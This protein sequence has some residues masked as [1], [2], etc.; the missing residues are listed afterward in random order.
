MQ[1][2]IFVIQVYNIIIITIPVASSRR[3]GSELGRVALPT[4]QRRLAL[5]GK[6]C[7]NSIWPVTNVTGQGNGLRSRIVRE[8]RAGPGITGK[9]N[10]YVYIYSGHQPDITQNCP[11]VLKESNSVL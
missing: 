3:S 5:S 9:A 11:I 10:I 1:Y 7:F 6:L 4:V 2:Y 8:K